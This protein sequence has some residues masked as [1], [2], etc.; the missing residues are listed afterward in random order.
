MDVVV[1]PLVWQQFEVGPL[2]E[3]LRRRDRSGLVV[4]H[5]LDGPERYRLLYA[6][7]LMEARRDQVPTV[8]QVPGGHA[9]QV[10]DDDIARSFGL[11]LVRPHRTWQQYEAMLDRHSVTYALVG[12]TAD[13]A[14]VVTRHER[15]TELLSSGARYRCNGPNWHGFPEPRVSIGDACPRQPECGRPDS[16]I[17]ED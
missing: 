17:Q 7:A 4:H 16:T 13:A 5:Q 1:L 14:M 12:E 6:G 10:V 15:E 3:L 11:D 2:L 8:G 9:V